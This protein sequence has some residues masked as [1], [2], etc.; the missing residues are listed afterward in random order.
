MGWEARA[1]PKPAFSF[2]SWLGQKRGPGKLLGGEMG[3]NQTHSP[4]SPLLTRPRSSK[5]NTSHTAFMENYSL[6]TWLIC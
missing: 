5:H 4:N 6:L 2:A 1:L 3:A